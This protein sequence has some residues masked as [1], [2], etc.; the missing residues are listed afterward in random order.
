MK[1][2]LDPRHERRKKAIKA[3]YSWGFS[4]EKKAKNPLAEKVLASLKKTD[5]LIGSCAP[6]WPV[7]QIN[8]ID[9]AILRL[10]VYEL[11]VKPKEPPKVII[12]EA[13]ELA[14]KYGSE[15]SPG[16]V[17]GVLGSVLKKIKSF[18]KNEKS[19]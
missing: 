16:F 6:E 11:A 15:K 5:K 9:L 17:N 19:K 1:T 10:A 13:I 18:K 7:A 3:L 2:A 14:K 4:K 8:R 12:D